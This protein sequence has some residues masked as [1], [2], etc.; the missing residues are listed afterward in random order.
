MVRL[1]THNTL[2]RLVCSLPPAIF[3]RFSDPPQEFT[4][5]S[6]LLTC[7]VGA[8]FSRLFAQCTTRER[9]ARTERLLA[10]ARWVGYSVVLFCCVVCR[11]QCCGLLCR[12]WL[13]GIV[14]QE[15]V[16]KPKVCRSITNVLLCVCAF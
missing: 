12:R 6:T 15:Q 3:K 1:N 16:I 8:F 7:F 14:A 13:Q 9:P 11:R 5:V 4:G 2:W 10:W